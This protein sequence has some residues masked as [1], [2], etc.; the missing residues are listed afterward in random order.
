MDNGERG[1]RLVAMA[2]NRH[3]RPPPVSRSCLSI[4]EL[5]PEHRDW[6]DYVDLIDGA[7]VT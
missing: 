7:G 3:K 4:H 1:R 6:N 5:T 2:A